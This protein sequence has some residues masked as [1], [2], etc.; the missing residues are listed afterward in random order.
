MPLGGKKPRGR[1]ASFVVNDATNVRVYVRVRPFNQREIDAGNAKP[2]VM[3]N[4]KES[5]M[6]DPE[7]GESKAERYTFDECFWSNK[8]PSA[9]PFVQQSDIYNIVGSVILDN[10]FVGYHSCLFAY[11][12]TGSGKTFTMMGVRTDAQLM[13]MIPRLSRGLFERMKDDSTGKV[14][15]VEVSYI[16]IYNEQLKDLLGN[17]GAGYA[18]VKI[19]D[20]PIYGPSVAGNTLAECKSFQDI[21]N[22]IN[23]GDKCRTVAA[24]AMNATSSRSHAVFTIMFTQQLKEQGGKEQKWFSKINLIDLAGSERVE[25]SG[26]TGQNFKEAVNIN[27][28]LTTLGR[29]MDALVELSQNKKGIIP[30]YRESML[31]RMLQDSLGGNSKTMMFANVSPAFINFEETLSTLRYSS[32]ARSI[33]NKAQVNT[34]AS[35]GAPIELAPPEKS[36]LDKLREEYERIIGGPTKEQIAECQSLQASNSSLSGEA[37][38]LSSKISELQSQLSSLTSAKGDADGRTAQMK[39]LQAENRDLESKKADLES[40][41]SAEENER[42]KLEAEVKK[43]TELGSSQSR[44]MQDGDAEIRRLR[45]QLDDLQKNGEAQRTKLQKEI[46]DTN[47]KLASERTK[48][49]TLEVRVRETNDNVKRAKEKGDTA[50]AD[51]ARQ[52]QVTQD[53]EDELKLLQS[54]YRQ[55]TNDNSGLIAREAAERK[56]VNEYRMKLAVIEDSVQRMGLDIPSYI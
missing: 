56:K 6:I 4:G 50:L 51:L 36:D 55:Q 29:V 46:S 26:V 41:K 18:D 52:S 3:V 45:Q 40:K 34:V 33:V 31:T 38:N 21:E 13:G 47:D 11:G 23:R 15:K 30:P 53:L 20:H 49:E 10:A 9:N 37:N 42:A 17:P 19:R 48:R 14:F 16:E 22:V 28:S 5:Y 25:D 24:T 27:K 39:Q 7:T 1:S 54:R 35:G 44:K 12:Q 8:E 43:L 2:A 32:R